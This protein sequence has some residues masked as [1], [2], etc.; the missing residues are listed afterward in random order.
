MHGEGVVSQDRICDTPATLRVPGD[1]FQTYQLHP[2]SS[3]TR[4]YK[5]CLKPPE[6]PNYVSVYNDDIIVHSRTLNE[7]LDHLHLVLEI[8]L[9]LKPAKCLFVQREVE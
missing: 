4:W 5:Y 7:H 6:G 9:I 8:G 3:N 2:L 1:A